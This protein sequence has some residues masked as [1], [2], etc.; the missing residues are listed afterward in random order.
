MGAY[1][2]DA[3]VNWVLIFIGCLLSMG[4]YYPYSTVYTHLASVNKTYGNRMYQSFTTHQ[5]KPYGELVTLRE[6]TL[7]MD[8]S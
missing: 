7:G 2:R 4:A 5:I 3:V 1:K 6:K 8:P